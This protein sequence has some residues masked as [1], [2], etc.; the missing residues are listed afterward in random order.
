MAWFDGQNALERKKKH[1]K[2]W[3]KWGYKESEFLPYHPEE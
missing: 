1:T 2:K 3:G